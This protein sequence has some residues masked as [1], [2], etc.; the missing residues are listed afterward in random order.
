MLPEDRLPRP[1]RLLRLT[2]RPT[3]LMAGLTAPPVAAYTAVLLA[4]TATPSWHSAYRELPFVFVSPL[5]PRP[6]ASAWSARPRSRPACAAH[7]DRGCGRRARREADGALHGD[8]RR[9]PSQG[10]GGEASR[11][12]PR[13]S[14]RSGQRV[15]CSA[16][17]PGGRG[18]LGAALMAG[19][20]CTRF[21]VFEAGQE[22][23]R[24]PKYTVV[25]QRERLDRGEPVRYHG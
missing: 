11:R 22:S 18:G 6:A 24:D 19:S 4:D 13:C 20:A 9:A 25:P 23:A 21:G 8:H 17:G 7:G 16:D 14:R 15:P 3:G 5:S 10:T 1:L 2:G 12:R